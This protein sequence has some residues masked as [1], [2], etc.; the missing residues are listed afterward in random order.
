MPASLA[1]HRSTA[2]PWRLRTRLIAILLAFLALACL[3]V[4]TV[5]YTAM[6]S[7]LTQQVSHQLQES[8]QRA[9][10]FDGHRPS[11][12]PGTGTTSR[13]APD[14]LEA[15]GQAAGTLNAR[16]V[17]GTFVHAGLLDAE[18]TSVGLSDAD[19][20]ALGQIRTADSAHQVQL[21]KGEYLVMAQ[22]ADD[23]STVITGLPLEPVHRTLTTLVLVMLGVSAAALVLAG[24]LGSVVIRRTMRPLERVAGV[25]GEVSGL[26]LE[27]QQ[28]PAGTRVAPRDA[29]PGTEVGEVGQALNR[30]LENVGSALTARQRSEDTVRAFVADA[31][32]ELRTP[33]AAI[34]GYSD[35]LR[36]TEPLSEEGS[37]SLARIDSQSTRMARLV[38]DLLLLARLDQGREPQ[39]TAVDLSE[40]VVENVSDMQVSAPD[41]HWVLALP[42]NPLEVRGDPEQLRQVLV[43]L[44]SNARKHT[45]AG[46]TVTVGLRRAGGSAVLSVADDG[47]GID[48]DF[49]PKIFERFARA[50]AARSGDVGTTGL[51]LAIVQAMV[52]A[53]GGEITVASRPGRTVFEVWLPVEAT[54]SV[55]GPLPP[56]PAAQGSGERS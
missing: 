33:L 42:E 25:A 7:S 3:A 8:S 47:P 43:N 40:L 22:E 38:E 5:S 51:G 31:S 53:H 16:I 13:Q 4:G 28:L 32:H 39:L 54:G 55:P 41:H 34:R 36:M 12:S 10:A 24:W 46:S 27:S 21:S 37:T 1:P 23:G 49:L 48:P 56:G 9:T 44:L 50:D 2:R 17:G 20:Q 6:K 29:R 35:L 14:P 45:D 19:E 15:P 11:G 26:D 52:R 18:G 30:L